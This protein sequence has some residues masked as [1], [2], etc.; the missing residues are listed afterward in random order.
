MLTAVSVTASKRRSISGS[1]KK[2]HDPPPL[3]KAMMISGSIGHINPSFSIALTLDLLCDATRNT[4]AKA[5]AI[6][7]S[8]AHK[9]TTCRQN[10]ILALY[11]L[12]IHLC[13]IM[14][15][16]RHPTRHTTALI[17]QLYLVPAMKLTTRRGT[18][19]SVAARSSV[20]GAS[21]T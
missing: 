2:S 16:L 20:P 5:K 6:Q 14:K 3:E 1:V 7:P 15:F 11:M 13:Q 8:P 12:H 4:P 10:G 21:S 18:G 17:P 9:N 19:D